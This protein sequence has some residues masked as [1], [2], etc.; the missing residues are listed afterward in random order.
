MDTSPDFTQDTAKSSP[1]EVDSLSQPAQN[2]SVKAA[3]P[4][5]MKEVHDSHAAVERIK[6][7]L[8]TLVVLISIAYGASCLFFMSMFPS[9]DPQVQK[10]VP[11][12]L[13]FVTIGAVVYILA[14]IVLIG[15]VMTSDAAIANRQQGV[16]RTIL[17]VAPCLALSVIVPFVISRAPA[18]PIDTL[19]ADQQQFVAPLSITLSAERTAKI[20]Q[21]LGQK[22]VQYVWYADTKGKA[23]ETTVTPKSTMLFQRAGVYNVGLRIVMSDGS[24]QKLSKQLVISQEVF[25]VAPDAPIVEQP[26]RFSVAQLIADPKQIKQIAWDFGDGKTLTQTTGTDT[27]HTFFSTGNFTV[28]AQV[29]LQN[30]AQKNY[31]RTVVV[32]DHPALPFPVTLTTDPKNLLGPSPFSVLF[33]IDT[34]EPL[35]QIEWDFGDNKQDRG[36]ELT[37]I[38]H[39]YETPGMYS[40]IMNA[41]SMSGTVA[42]ITTIVRVTDVLR[43]DD[44]HFQ[45]FP[46]MKSN[47]IQGEVPYT[48]QL[49]PQ[50]SMSLI[51]FTWEAPEELE[52]VITG[53]SLQAVIRREG[54]Y[55]V[56]LIAQGPDGSSM[57]LPIKV[58]IAPPGAEPHF[59]MHPGS[60]TAPLD[61]TF[62]ASDTYVPPGE[63]VA[64]F[65]WV[66]GDEKD[67]NASELGGSRIEHTFTSAGEYQVKLDVVMVS[68][69]VFSTTQTIIVRNPSIVACATASKTQISVGDSVQFDST[70]S[71]GTPSSILW[72]IRLNDQPKVVIAQGATAVY[73]HVFDQAGDYTI[74]LSIRDGAGNASTKTLSLS[75]LP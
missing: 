44:L 62:D 32:Q 65:K 20:L 46:T 45:E 24:V 33:T 59:S 16:L 74:T 41:R 4:K 63:S 2:E 40:V 64:G 52:P 48:L 71:T 10:M 51:Q 17:F 31:S 49:T 21:D 27:A 54:T 68:G 39:S 11:S 22:P 38:G 60:G 1:Q 67:P 3:A 34:K 13:G 72:D 26:A 42:Q 9:I 73:S 70:C 75:V 53:S 37:R 14:G 28:T 6:W 56:T 36:P 23:T 69:K 58:I 29:T 47:T 19:P 8:L 55:F 35:K 25:T 18:Y 12:V 7:F 15:R 57:R 50:T 61:V 5:P 66:F 43:I 30:S